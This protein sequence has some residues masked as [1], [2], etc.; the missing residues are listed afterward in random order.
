LTPAFSPT[1]P[2]FRDFAMVA[3]GSTAFVYRAVQERL[4]RV[5]AVKVLLIDGDM[6]TTDSVAK[7]LEATVLVS[8]HPHIVSIIDTGA[9]G[10]GHPYIVMEYCEG[11]SYSAVLKDEG[12]LGV[13][14][15][16]EVG[17]KIGQAL[18]AA[19]RAGILHRDV[20]PQ[21]ILRGRYG[22]ALADFGIARAPEALAA[23]RAIDMLTPLHASPEA[24]LRRAQTPAS[25]LYSLASTMWHLLAGYA[26]FANA[27]GGT[28]PEVHRE[29]VTSDAPP[30]K[31]PRADV[32][33]WLEDLLARS[34][35]RD[36]D[37][38]P[39]SCGAF[40]ES[41]Q[42]QALSD[43]LAAKDEA[44]RT[45]AAP[46]EDTVL[47]SADRAGTDPAP[48]R[49]PFAADPSDRPAPFTPPRPSGPVHAARPPHRRIRPELYPMLT[50]VIVTVV[51]VLGGVGIVLAVA[52]SVDG[53]D[54]R[55]PSPSGAED[56]LTTGA[57]AA[58]AQEVAISLVDVTSTSFTVHTDAEAG[59]LTCTTAVKETDVEVRGDCG[60]ITV[61]GLRAGT[62]YIFVIEVDGS[63]QEPITEWVSTSP[64]LGR[65]H[66]ECPPSL[67]HCSD[68]GAEVDVGADP[69]YDELLGTAAP[70][71]QIYLYCYVETAETL[72]PRGEETGEYWDY[73]PGKDASNL[74]VEVD[75]G[76]QVGYIPFVWLVLDPDDPN[77]TASL[78][79]C[80][81]SPT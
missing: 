7:E 59:A 21:N 62:P 14:D 73:H 20:K 57:T 41:L 15:V 29:R 64:V 26:P 3:H 5:V 80:R 71:D 10:E 23:T 22:P 49:S 50:A 67:E 60:E 11:G 74:A 24:L 18:Q 78:A 79:P 35:S 55:T 8:G 12:P 44:E 70:G 13:E 2:G 48:T 30:P 31:L 58:Q 45:V 39:A 76:G 19:H 9:T 16:V 34:L 66:F 1:I 68:G 28:D 65:V 75:Y 38:R 36:P 52:A 54:P 40:A 53:D 72:T 69:D 56:P 77:S 43:H 46:A 81:P 47:V 25:D 37:R 51:M 4:D 42:L 32:P 27:E 61:E 33:E 6:T 63:D 17:V